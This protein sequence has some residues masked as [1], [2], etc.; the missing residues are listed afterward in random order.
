M[1]IHH[2]STSHKV[3]LSNRVMVPRQC[4]PVQPHIC[5]TG[6][7]TRMRVTMQSHMHPIRP[8]LY[9]SRREQVLYSFY[10]RNIFSTSELLPH[11][12]HTNRLHLVCSRPHRNVGWRIA[13]RNLHIIWTILW[14]FIHEHKTYSYYP[15]SISM[16]F[17]TGKYVSLC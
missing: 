4:S 11:W 8:T 17:I 7:I 12:P 6:H 13:H 14:C 5:T 3:S 2:M 15:G 9:I 16:L 1:P 10:V